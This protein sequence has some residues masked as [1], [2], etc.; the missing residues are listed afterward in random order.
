MA[1]ET[2]VETQT[3]KRRAVVRSERFMQW[4]RDLSSRATYGTR[5]CRENIYKVDG[6]SIQT[7]HDKR[8]SIEETG[9]KPERQEASKAADRGGH[10][11]ELKQQVI[12]AYQTL[13]PKQ[14]DLLPK[15]LNAQSHC[16]THGL[17]EKNFELIQSKGLECPA[18]TGGRI[19]RCQKKLSQ[20]SLI[21]TLTLQEQPLMS[22]PKSQSTNNHVTRETL[23]ASRTQ[24]R[25]PRQFESLK[26]ADKSLKVY[27][28]ARKGRACFLSRASTKICK[29]SKRGAKRSVNEEPPLPL[30]L[31]KLH[32]VLTRKEI[33][34]DWLKITGQSYIGKPK[35]STLVQRGF[36]LCTKLTCPSTIRYLTEPQ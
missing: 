36:G 28:R 6:N 4:H 1:M 17:E 16:G 21:T 30:K 3:G 5:R 15:T 33:Q 20:P 2:L 23:P 25:P 11:Q 10:D 9:D 35:R 7:W 8:P 29:R 34:E 12:E 24:R 18:K 14:P 27:T 26:D 19:R 13:D 32:L 22:P 31:P